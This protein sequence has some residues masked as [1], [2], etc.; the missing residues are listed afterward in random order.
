ML[1]FLIKSSFIIFLHFFVFLSLFLLI[2]LW[3]GKVLRF[4]IKSC[5]L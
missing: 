3:P 1:R 2:K 4:L 5:F